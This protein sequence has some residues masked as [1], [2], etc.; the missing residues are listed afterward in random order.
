MFIEISV[1]N[2]VRLTKIKEFFKFWSVYFFSAKL[3][4]YREYY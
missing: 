3:L 4:L 2:H 1:R